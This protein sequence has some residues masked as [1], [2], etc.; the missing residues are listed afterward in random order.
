MDHKK[1]VDIFNEE[2][3]KDGESMRKTVIK[4]E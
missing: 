3:F 1:S 2:E 4:P